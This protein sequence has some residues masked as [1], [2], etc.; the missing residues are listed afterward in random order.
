MTIKT[1]LY[2]IM[3]PISIYVVEALNIE[4]F[5]KK[6]KR[7]QIVVAY[8]LLSVCLTYLVVNFLIDF[9]VS[10]KTIY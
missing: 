10:T 2:F 3:T 8:V 9:F 5:F 7:A 4:R 6:N 1:V